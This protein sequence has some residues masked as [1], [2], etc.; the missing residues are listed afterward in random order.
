MATCAYCGATIVFGGS[1]A[2]N[3]RYCNATC[4]Q[5]GSLLALS[6]QIPDAEIRQQVWAV[7]QGQCPQCSGSGPV[8][9]HTSYKV[10]SFLV[11]TR[12]VNTPRVSCRSCGVKK[13]MGG[14]AVSL[15]LGWWGIPWGLI[16]TP[17]Q[18]VRN[19]T[20]AMSG[21]DPGRPS[22]ALEKL[23]RVNAASRLVRAA[24]AAR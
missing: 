9:V 7:H 23:V 15:F 3:L 4:A 17:V 10:Y 14:L 13:Q 21:P 8:D 11:M 2:G 19:L 24:P 6:R 18:I 12:W 16:M 22:P 1:R 20:G 5:R